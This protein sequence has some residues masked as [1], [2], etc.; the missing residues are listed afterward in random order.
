[1]R[2]LDAYL[3]NMLS[4]P[5]HITVFICSRPWVW[6]SLNRR[7]SSWCN[8]VGKK[9]RSRWLQLQ[10]AWRKPAQQPCRFRQARTGPTA[11]SRF[12][13]KRR[14]ANS[15][16]RHPALTPL[17]PFPPAQDADKL[18]RKQ[19]DDDLDEEFGFARLT[20]GPPQTGFI[21]NLRQVSLSPGRGPLPR[22]AS[23]HAALCL[24]LVSL[25][26]LSGPSIFMWSPAPPPLLQTFVRED[27]T[28]HD[29]S[30]LEC[31]LLRD[32]GSTFKAVTIYAP[33]MLVAVQNNRTENEIEEW[34]ARRFEGLVTAVDVLWKED[35]D[36]ANHLSGL[37]RKYLKLSFR[38]TADLMTVRKV[39]LPAVAENKRRMATQDAYSETGGAAAAASGAARSAMGDGDAAGGG[40][41]SGRGGGAGGR[42]EGPGHGG[43]LGAKR[44]RADQVLEAFVEMREYDV[45]Y[46]QRVQIDTGIRVGL[47][48]TVTPQQGMRCGLLAPMCRTGL[49]RTK[50][51][52]TEPLATN[53]LQ[54]HSF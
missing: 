38:N 51:P 8:G 54:S 43:V 45:A 37:K 53:T 23:A 29:L 48:Y 46:P 28:G 20:A 50:T 21:Y 15:S 4:A 25:N 27:E 1:M 26:V 9:G 41:S 47:W 33:Y 5:Q 6:E 35:L 3:L 2:C 10:E 44:R 12:T 40:G 30:A 24:P 39:I 11:P 14:L 13:R 17:T 42:N 31:Y 52:L 34:L 18:A 32:D 7:E 36:L 16:L 22:A 19:R 49:T